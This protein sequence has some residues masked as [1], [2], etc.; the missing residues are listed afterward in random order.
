MKSL[1]NKK[2]VEEDV[3]PED[4][5]DIPDIGGLLRAARNIDNYL[6]RNELNTV[7]T[8][9]QLHRDLKAALASFPRRE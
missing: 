1:E 9:S 7:G 5:G 6:S 8:E 3:D 4:W 2:I